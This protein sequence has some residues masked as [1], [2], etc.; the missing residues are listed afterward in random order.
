MA[1]GRAT[2][3]LGCPS[4]QSRHATAA[5]GGQEA[6]QTHARRLVS[7]RPDPPA[8]L[9]VPLDRADLR[10]RT[11]SRHRVALEGMRGSLTPANSQLKAAAKARQKARL[12]A[13]R[14]APWNA[15]S[16]AHFIA[17]SIAQLKARHI[18][19]RIA[20]LKAQR[21]AS[22]IAR[23]KARS[24]DRGKARLKAQHKARFKA[25]FTA[26]S[27]APQRASPQA[28]PTLGF[29]RQPSFT[30]DR[31]CRRYGHSGTPRPRPPRVLLSCHHRHYRNQNLKT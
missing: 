10:H 30:T 14:K 2:A 31:Q 28:T 17:S 29:H 22:F 19:S 1:A 23:C 8:G 5:A 15:Y 4:T 27:K 25:S 21:I 7:R 26:S 20:Y 9:S 6:G 24:K 11:A 12:S 18:A 16:K 3:A 13:R